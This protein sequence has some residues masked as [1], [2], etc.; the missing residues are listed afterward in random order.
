MHW[1]STRTLVTGGASVRVVDNLSSGRAGY[2]RDLDVDF[3]E[4]DLL[5][6]VL[7]RRAVSGT[8][9]VF[10]LA[11]DHPAEVAARLETALTER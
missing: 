10:H 1:A 4:A 3:L 9:V 7:A 8:D 5:D 2:L 11:A 6:Q